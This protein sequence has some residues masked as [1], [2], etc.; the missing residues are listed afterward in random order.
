[1]KGT[2]G[3]WRSKIAGWRAAEKRPSTPL[4]RFREPLTFP[5][6]RVLWVSLVGESRPFHA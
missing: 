6:D 5:E 3:E 2:V 4:C 1:M